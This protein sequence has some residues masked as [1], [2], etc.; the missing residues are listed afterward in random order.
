VKPH[1][2]SCD[3]AYVRWRGDFAPF[4]ARCFEALREYVRV[5]FDNLLDR[6]YCEGHQALNDFPAWAFESYLRKAERAGAGQDVP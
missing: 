6:Y 1:R 4:E 2:S 5:H 3:P